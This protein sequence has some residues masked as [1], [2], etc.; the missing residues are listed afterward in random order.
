MP[1]P[2]LQFGVLGKSLLCLTQQTL[3]AGRTAQL[4]LIDVI[5]FVVSLVGV[6]LRIREEFARM[7]VCVHGCANAL[8]GAGTCSGL[9]ATA[10]P[11]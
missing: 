2:A 4:C 8:A 1:W 10:E 3:I 9:S 7:C 6:H 11:R 5:V